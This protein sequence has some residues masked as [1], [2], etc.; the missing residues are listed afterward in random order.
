MTLEDFLNTHPEWRP[1]ADLVF[2]PPN[3]AE[4]LAEFPDSDNEVRANSQAGFPA[5][6]AL[7][8]RMRREGSDD[9]WA[10]MCALR[11]PARGE[12]TDTFWAGRK[13]FHEVYG[14]EYADIVRAVLKRQGI[15]LKPGDE[16]MPELANRLGD[17]EAVVPFDGARSYIKNLCERRGMACDGA[18]KTEHRQPETDPWE[19]SVTLAPDLVKKNA[20]R[21]LKKNPDLRKL[22]RR[23]LRAKVLEEHGASK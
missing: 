8:V 17:K 21:M 5:V 10:A 14:E 2:V 18:V 13:P 3:D 16:Y 23:E 19:E 9:R 11:S 15:T 7:Y 22:D 12:T 1:Y 20:Q 6:G 4:I